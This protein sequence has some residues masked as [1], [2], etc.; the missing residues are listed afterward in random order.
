M[1]KNAL[2]VSCLSA[3]LSLLAL[4]CTTT[5]PRKD[6]TGKIFPSV[7]G[8]ALDDK[9]WQLPEDLKG[10]NTLLLI[11]YKQES[12]FDIDRWLIGI[13]QV[14]VNAPT[15]E[16]PTIRGWVPRL[17][18]DEI[19]A[20]MRD[21]IPKELWKIVITVYKDA[22][23]IVDFTGNENPSNARVIVLNEGGEVL[24]MHDQGFSV[25][26]LNKISRFFPVFEGKSHQNCNK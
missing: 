8:T 19:D 15:F 24:A 22:D 21:G 13:D 17:I 10:Q 9:T 3:I 26:A 25:A 14:G 5:I 20:G 2:L 1:K 11:G 23:K 7:S 16:I 12:Q 18:A 6:Q 4:G